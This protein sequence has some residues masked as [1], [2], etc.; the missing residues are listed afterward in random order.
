MN[1]IDYRTASWES[2]KERLSGLRQKVYEALQASGPCTTRQLAQASGID[3]LT[4]RPRITELVELGFA[5]CVGGKANE[6]TYAA[7][8]IFNA[9][10]QFQF[11]QRQA[12]NPQ[13]DLFED[14]V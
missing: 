6:G 13:L 7:R 8:S 11:K 14:A 1:P 12:K 4:V 9:Q 3:I 10:Q 5:E 2:I